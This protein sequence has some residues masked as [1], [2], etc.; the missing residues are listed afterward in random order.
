[1]YHAGPCHAEIHGTKTLKGSVCV[2]AVYARPTAARDSDL[3]RVCVKGASRKGP[4][5]AP[6]AP[7]GPMGPQGPHAPQGAF[8]GPLGPQGPLRGHRGT[9]GEPPEPPGGS[10]GIFGKTRIL[11][12]T[13]PPAT[14]PGIQPRSPPDWPR[15]LQNWPRSPQDWPWT[16]QEWPRTP[17]DSHGDLDTGLDPE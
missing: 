5:R 9:Q 10:P 2:N 8:L 17:Q 7:H 4:N 12:R 11:A 14:D 13:R 15:S 16:P 1:M 6:R 3:G